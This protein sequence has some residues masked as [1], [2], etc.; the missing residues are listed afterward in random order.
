MNIYKL[1]LN[2]TLNRLQ[3]FDDRAGIKVFITDCDI[4]NVREIRG[5][6]FNNLIGHKFNYHEQSIIFS[7]RDVNSANNDVVV[8][9]T[10]LVKDN[11]RSQQLLNNPDTN[12]PLLAL[13]PSSTP[14]KSSDSL[15]GLMQLTEEEEWE[16]RRFASP[17]I[18]YRRLK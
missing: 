5:F 8:S 10:S 6:E 9:Y 18:F 14:R 1:R 12:R 13:P 15:V 17:D 3:I 2:L 4:L 7:Y 11:Y 16:V